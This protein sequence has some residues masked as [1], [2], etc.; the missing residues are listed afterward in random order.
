[1]TNNEIKMLSD[2]LSSVLIENED[3]F[4]EEWNKKC[5]SSTGK[6]KCKIL[7]LTNLYYMVK[8]ERISRQEAIQRQKEIFKGIEQY[9]G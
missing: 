8:T 4:M 1:M 2:M 3:K 5:N 7:D 6:E 9:Y